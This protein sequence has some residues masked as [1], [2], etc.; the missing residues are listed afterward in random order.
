[1]LGLFIVEGCSSRDFKNDAA[2]YISSLKVE[3]LWI[4]VLFILSIA[5]NM[6][7]RLTFVIQYKYKGISKG[8]L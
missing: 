8:F 4:R 1:M 6:N 5:C 2:L 7:N 3:V